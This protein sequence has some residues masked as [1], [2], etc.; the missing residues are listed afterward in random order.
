MPEIDDDKKIREIGR[1]FAEKNPGTTQYWKLDTPQAKAE[2][3][4]I[5]Y[6]YHPNQIV[7]FET[8]MSP[9]YTKEQWPSEKI[10]LER[11]YRLGM[12]NK[13]F[14]LG[15]SNWDDFSLVQDID[16]LYWVFES[17]DQQFERNPTGTLRYLLG[18]NL[19]IIGLNDEG[20]ICRSDL[21]KIK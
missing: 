12:F 5:L 16:K 19:G 13:I 17:T 9:P 3:F 10:F 15:P 21:N 8:T 7:A 2:F 1:K 11:C 6:G 14:R 18:L 20:L 4:R